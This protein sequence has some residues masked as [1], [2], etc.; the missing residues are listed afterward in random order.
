MGGSVVHCCAG[1]DLLADRQPICNRLASKAPTPL[2]AS[3][4]PLRL[5]RCKQGAMVPQVPKQLLG[6]PAGH[7][8]GTH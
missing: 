1:V 7:A 3:E 5:L 8:L 6:C 4:P 2:A